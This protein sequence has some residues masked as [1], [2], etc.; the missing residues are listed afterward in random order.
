MAYSEQEKKIL[1]LGIFIAAL[2]VGGSIYYYLMFA[3]KDIEL[4]KTKMEKI[5]DEVK[6]IDKDLKSMKRFMGKED[7]IA[8]MKKKVEAVS[9]RLPSSP[10]EYEFL[11]ELINVL[12]LSKVNQHL[13]KP[14]PYATQT[15]YTEIPYNID[16]RARYHEFGTFLNLVEENQNRFMRINSFKINNDTNRPSVHPISVGISTFMFNR[17][18]K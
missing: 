4:N 10:D 16:I 8:A 7:E 15:L 17:R 1:F 2:L 12:R 11:Q 13:L 14:Q 9:K 6:A 3:K 5:N 18:A